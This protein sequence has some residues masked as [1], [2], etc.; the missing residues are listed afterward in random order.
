MKPAPKYAKLHSPHSVVVGET[1]PSEAMAAAGLEAN[2]GRPLGI[3]RGS[4]IAGSSGSKPGRISALDFTKGA[5]VLVMVLYHWLNYFVSSQGSFYRYLSFLPPSF[6][7]ITGFLIAQV[8]LSK[9]RIGDP[10]LPRRLIVRGLKLL[11]LFI[12]LNVG[13]SLLIAGVYHGRRVFDNSSIS[14]LSSVF[15]T[16]NMTGGRTVAFY[17]LVPISYLLL[18]SALLVIAHRY[19]KHVFHATTL[20]CFLAILILFLNGSKSGNLELVTIGLLGISIGH[21]PI[22]KINYFLRHPYTVIVA[23]LCYVA[24]ITVWNVPYPLQVAGVLLTLSV[25]YLAGTVS[26]KSGKMQ[27][28]LIMLGKYSLFGYIAQIAI[29]QLL[30]RSL[31]M[32]LAPWVLGASFLAAIALTLFAVRVVDRARANSSIVDRMYAVVFS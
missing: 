9:S 2:A 20:M 10:R 3:T 30:R 19:Y 6:I 22:D 31:G 12:L 26:G 15:V 16:G 8:Y 18:L 32:A 5:L 1:S 29:L 14:S 27:G 11:M 23:Y 25:I 17:V 4:E 7:C 24:A 28:S 13:T 21:I